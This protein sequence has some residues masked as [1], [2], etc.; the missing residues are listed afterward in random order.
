MKKAAGVDHQRLTSDAVST[1]QCY[2]LIGN[3]ILIRCPLEK[4]ALFGL[5]LEVGVDL[6]AA[7]RDTRKPRTAPRAAA[8]FARRPGAVGVLVTE[9]DQGPL[10]SPPAAPAATPR[11]DVHAVD[12]N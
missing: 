9:T 5:L 10:R 12:E 8:H 4:R 7:P 6:L 3:V 1:A 2:H 11:H